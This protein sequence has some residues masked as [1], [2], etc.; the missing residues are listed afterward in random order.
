NSLALGCGLVEGKPVA[1][2][3]HRVTI[4]R[5][6]HD[7]D[8]GALERGIDGPRGATLPALFAQHEPRFERLAQLEGYALVRDRSPARKAELKVRQEPPPI[9]L[10]PSAHQLGDD[11]LEIPPDEV[12]QHESVVQRRAP[13]HERGAIRS[14]PEPRH[15]GTDEQLLGQ[16]HAW[17]RW[18]LE[19]AQLHQ[20]KTAHGAFR[21]IK[22]VDADLSAVGVASDV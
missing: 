12:W 1:V 19:G 6:A 16:A 7:G 21:R 3:G 22:F 20:T 4:H 18:H 17:V 9:E 11:A 13:A 5:R 10:Q 2:A 14:L 15:Q 8:L